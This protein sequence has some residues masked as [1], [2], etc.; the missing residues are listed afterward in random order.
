MP[1]A[2]IENDT[3]SALSA[4]GHRY[5]GGSK[6]IVDSS[7]TYRDQ[8]YD[9]NPGLGPGTSK[10]VNF[11][12]VGTFYVGPRYD[13]Q[14]G[15]DQRYVA[16]RSVASVFWKSHSA[17]AGL[18]YLHTSIDGVNGQGLT[19]VVATEQLRPIRSRQLLH[20]AGARIHQSGRRPFGDAQPRHEP[21]RAGRLAAAS[22]G[23]AESWRAVGLRFTVQR[24]RQRGAEAGPGLV[25]YRAHHRE[26]GLGPVLRSLPSRPG[27]GGSRVR[28]I[29][30]QVR[31]RVQLPAAGR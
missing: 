16:G 21:V 12:G 10:Q 25:D 18:E 1:S 13:L 28:R 3:E 5:F 24:R 7:L 19:T 2:S 9:V 27:A 6:L 20:P 17:K 14:Q 29:Q 23:H 8:R 26:G 30:W 4:F 31:R 22:V 15:L 11:P